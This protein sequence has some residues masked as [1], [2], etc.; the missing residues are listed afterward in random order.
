MSTS[1]ITP[2]TTQENAKVSLNK[3]LESIA[4][5][6]FLIMLGCQAFVPAERVNEGYWSIGVGIIL[7]GLNVARYRYQIR[8]SGFTMALGIIALITG[9]GELA[10]TDLP[11]LAIL[12]ILLGANLVLKPWFEELKLFGKAEES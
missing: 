5:G 11:G 8:M 3:R 7:L 6:L 12:L 10:G 1:M 4:W 9:V 2:S